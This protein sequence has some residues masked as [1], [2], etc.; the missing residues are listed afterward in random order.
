MINKN[1]IF[2]SLEYNI[3]NE[4][5]K[6]CMISNDH[7]PELNADYQTVYSDLGGGA[8]IN[9]S[10]I[11]SL[12]KYNVIYLTPLILLLH[13][14]LLVVPTGTTQFIITTMKTNHK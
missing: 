3:L 12:D 13:P 2:Q 6:L 8:N 9:L 4:I 5:P 11:F 1:P 10:L 14:G 7:F